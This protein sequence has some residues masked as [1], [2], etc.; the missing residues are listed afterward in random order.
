MIGT[1]NWSDIY[2]E[3]ATRLLEY[4]ND[5][6]GLISKIQNVYEEID[7]KLPK[8]ESNGEYIG[9]RSFYDFWII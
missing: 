1:F 5:R 9:Y 2:E 3:F 7:M 4:K 6:K 8:M